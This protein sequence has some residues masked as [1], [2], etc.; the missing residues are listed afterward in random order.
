ML[1]FPKKNEIRYEILSMEKLQLQLNRRFFR[2]PKDLNLSELETNCSLK[3]Q[4]C[5]LEIRLIVKCGQTSI[6][7]QLFVTECHL[8]KDIMKHPHTQHPSVHFC[9]VF[10]GPGLIFFT[11]LTKNLR[12]KKYT[13]QTTKSFKLF[14]RAMVLK[15]IIQKKVFE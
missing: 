1:L 12:R 2:S 7:D 14:V 9:M 13:E 4:Y 5:K 11:N 10:L 3:G 15:K 6:Y 8:S